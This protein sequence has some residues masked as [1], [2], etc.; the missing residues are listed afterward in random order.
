MLYL[1]IISPTCPCINPF[2]RIGPLEDHYNWGTTTL[3]QQCNP[4]NPKP[5][6]PVNGT[7]KPSK[8]PKPETSSISR[9]GLGFTAKDLGFRTS[10]LGFR[11]E[12][13]GFRASG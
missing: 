12:S 4:L 6:N 13:L 7:L 8:K 5:S 2:V 3:N 9:K 1:R 11:L 10:G